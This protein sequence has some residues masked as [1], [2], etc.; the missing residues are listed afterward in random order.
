MNFAQAS[1]CALRGR[2]E[3]AR[4]SLLLLTP[5]WV[6][7][8]AFGTIVGMR[9][10][11]GCEAG[12]SSGPAAGFDAGTELAP[13]LSAG[14]STACAAVR[15]F[16]ASSRPRTSLRAS[17]G[18]GSTNSRR[19]RISDNSVGDAPA[20]S[21]RFS[22]A[23]TSRYVK[24]PVSKERRTFVNADA[25]E[26]VLATIN[27]VDLDDLGFPGHLCRRCS[28][29]APTLPGRHPGL[30]YYPEK[31]PVRQMACPARRVR[32]SPSV[33][34]KCDDDR[35]PIT[36]TASPA[37]WLHIR[38]SSEYRSICRLSPMTCSKSSP[39]VSRTGS[40][41]GLICFFT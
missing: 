12:I 28:K 26:D 19:R 41:T 2:P 33:L 16:A 36:P 21:S 10:V 38:P 11:G 1:R 3:S 35:R 40:A 5:V 27:V 23:T 7:D 37:A 39:S 22:S 32:N 30:G 34:R 8:P 20:L 4:G 9:T 25:G 14:G 15:S 24:P 17:T 6:S 31:S 13:A 29:R 18:N